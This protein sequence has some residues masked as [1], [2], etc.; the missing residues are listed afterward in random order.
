[1]TDTILSVLQEI[2]DSTSPPEKS[3]GETGEDLNHWQSRTLWNI[4]TPEDVA[5]SILTFYSDPMEEFLRRQMVALKAENTA[6]IH[7]WEKVWEAMEAIGFDGR[8]SS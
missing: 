2:L 7:F 4:T 8:K 1:M 3:T 6:N 5:Y